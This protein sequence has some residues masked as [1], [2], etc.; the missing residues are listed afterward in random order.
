MTLVEVL[1]GL[2]LLAVTAVALLQIQSA[3]MRQIQRAQA[4]AQAAVLLED[5]LW[6][7]QLERTPVT[8]PAT[9]RLDPRWTWRRTVQPVAAAP[10][11]LAR[12]I[13]VAVFAEEGPKTAI[14]EVC[15]LLPLDPGKEGRR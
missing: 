9:G 7:W 3:S 14:H 15:W 4:R 12:E 2:A 10:G 5:L 13:R 6:Q 11:V 1:C 8:L